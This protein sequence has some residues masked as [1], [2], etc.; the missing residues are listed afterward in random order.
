MKIGKVFSVKVVS[1]ILIASVALLYSCKK[2]T[3]N[4]LSSTDSQ[5][6]NSESVSSATTSETAD[7]GSSIVNNTSDTQLSGARFEANQVD[8]VGIDG[9]LKGATITITP[10][11]GSTFKVPQ[12]TIKIDFG[13][14]QTDANGVTRKGVITITYYGRRYQTGSWRKLTFSGYSRTANSNTITFDDATTYT[15]TNVTDSTASVFKFH[16]ELANA[17]LTFSIDNTTIVRNS[18]VVVAW[19]K[20]AGT[21][22]HLAKTADITDSAWGTSRKGINYTMDITKDLVY[23]VSCLASKVYIPVSGTKLFKVGNNTTVD[24]TIDYGD[25]TCDN[26]VTVTLNGKSKQITVGGDGN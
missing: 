17:T 20:T 5:N 19:D 24:Y 3:D 7:M 14:G 1:A 23:K 8:W 9:R 18:N 11:A 25:G 12:G 26:T 10:S 13:S 2:D 16:H 15:V 4:V 21:I 6:A 22:T